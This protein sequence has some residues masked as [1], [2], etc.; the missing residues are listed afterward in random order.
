MSAQQKFNLSDW[1]LHHRALVWYFM[2]VASLAGILA[3]MNLGREEDP[4]FTIKTMLIQAN[5]PGATVEQ[6]LEQVTERIE[7]RLEA[8]PELDFSRSMTTPGQTV[9][10]VNL[11]DSVKG[12]QVPQAFAKLRNSIGDIRGQLPDGVVGPFFNDD[13][14][15][16]YG[17]IYAFTADGLDWR[18]LRDHVDDVR[19]QLLGVPNV[20]KIELIGAQ[21]EAI[22]LEF[23]TR[24][25]AALGLDQ[26]QIIQSLQA[27][28]AV[29]PSGVVEAGPQRVSIRVSG[30]FVSE[31]SLREVNLR[32]GG[33]FLR[34]GDVATV[35]RGPVDPP[36]S[37]FRFDGEPA[38]GL[39]VGMKAGANL[40]EF[41]EALHAEMARIVQNLPLGVEAHLVADQPVVVEEAVG[42][43]L[44]AL[45][46]AVAFVLLVSLV[47]LGLR[48]GLVVAISIPLVLG[49]TFLSMQYL[50]I[51]LQRISL[52][53]LI[54]ALGLLVDDAMIAV[55][56]MVARLEAGDPLPVAATHV[57]AHTAFP[58]L[59]GTLATVAGFMP[60][61]LNDSMSGEYTHSLFVVI[62]VALIVSWVVAVL[63]VPLLGVTILPNKLK[64]HAEHKGFLARIFGGLLRL[65]M[66][67][68]WL[69][70]LTTI[71]AF[72]GAVFLMRFVEQ[73]FF[74]A[75][76]RPELIVDMS[77]PHGSSFAATQARMDQLESHLKGDPDVASWS[78]YVGQTA[79]RFVL[80]FD[81][82]P[83]TPAFGQ[84]VII[85]KD[86][87]ARD[88]L[89]A[90]LQALARKDFVGVDMQIK[91]LPLG[92]PAGRPVQ[93]RLSGPDIQI[94]RGLARDLANVVE[95]HPRVYD[96]GFDW[97]EAALRLTVQVDQ[98]KA[99]QLGISSQTVAGILQG[100]VGGVPVTQLRDDVYAIDVI[101]RAED[102]ERG[103]LETLQNLQIATGDG[104]SIPLS[105]VASFSY[106]L[107]QPVV[108][109]RSR[110]PTI[111]V[112]GG[113]LDS[114]QPT[115][116]VQ[117]L[118]PKI[119][120]FAASLPT[121]YRISVA[122]PVE[123]SA[124][125]QGPIAAVVPLMLLTMATVLMIQLQ[126]FSRLFLVFSVAPLA[127]IGVAPALL[128]TNSPMGFVA[129][130]GILALAGILI[131]NSVILIMQIEELRA[132]GDDPWTAVIEATEHRMRPIMLTAV[133][134]T[135]ALYPIA[136][137]GFWGPMAYSMMGG[138]MAGT[139]L[140]LLFLPALYVT[141]FRIRPLAPPPPPPPA[142]PPP[143][144]LAEEAASPAPPAPLAIS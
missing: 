8:L 135:L 110:V 131:R 119:E 33:R 40:L 130:L 59:T 114:T 85:A 19:V 82:L 4:S 46:E 66:R 101:S 54:I 138:I 74:P 12:P 39:G 137:Q 87:E 136:H 90:R 91:L 120:A 86:V 68:R 92:P 143:A 26:N 117:E 76:D 38:I 141:W 17:N 73:A 1:A 48:A 7:R 42:G 15:D 132:H 65:A 140:T 133:A 142:E 81:V 47:S 99:R 3:Y 55:E 41:G 107:E 128:I 27:Q 98:E 49:V 67:F 84:S 93:Y 122:G 103:S 89:R 113:V 64:K 45:F 44:K 35:T 31:D 105:A 63:F 60:I 43:F 78:S 71:L 115:T 29:T 134:A 37:V 72:C 30:G 106:G 2:I 116:I 5:W 61:G 36:S 94:L 83:A 129:I 97:M 121:G 51:S 111:T 9:I 124:K 144:P 58:M 109:R 23:S 118:T 69:T 32:V 62:A 79:M 96:V 25:M 77:L 75:S 28:N 104:G 14:G 20:G 123:E 57:Y 88:R 108:W 10:F 95:S 56:M 21:D 125:A 127:V 6:T 112:Q 11:N 100:V 22:Y 70:I 80:S 102:D 18:Q 24:R 50:D 52:G 53:A 34:L 16:V 139:I 13:F 126:S